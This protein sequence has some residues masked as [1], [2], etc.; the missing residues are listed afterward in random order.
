M[1][2]GDLYYI[3]AKQ[4]G[5][6]Y[7]ITPDV[8]SDWLRAQR[9]RAEYSRLAPEA[10]TEEGQYAF[11]QRKR[12]RPAMS[13]AENVLVIFLGIQ[14]VSIKHWEYEAAQSGLAEAESVEA[15][16]RP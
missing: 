16:G 12:K 5:G 2:S 10:A 7:G 9:W 3:T 14:G 8:G 1:L 15:A 13:E 6:R 4:G 11:V